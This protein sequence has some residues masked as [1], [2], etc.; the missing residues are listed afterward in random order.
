V[1]AALR[2]EAEQRMGARFD[3]KAFHDAVLDGGA[4]PLTVL[5]RR[6]REWA[7]A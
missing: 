3:A 5:Q 2:A 7:G 6:V 4:M 1:I